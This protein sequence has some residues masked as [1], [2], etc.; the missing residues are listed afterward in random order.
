MSRVSPVTFTGNVT[1]K[2]DAKSRVSVPATWR[3]AHGAVLSLIEAKKKQFPVLKCY[4]QEGFE[5]MLTDIRTDAAARGITPGAINEYIGR[6][7]GNS[8]GAEV[9]TQGKLLIPKA[10][11]ERLRITDSVVLVGRGVYFELWNPEDFAADNSP[12][13]LEL[14]Q[15]YNILS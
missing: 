6:I 7:A 8:F 2:P 13:Q 1:H 3:A 15:Y 9:S 14:D 10:Q 5:E 11:R 4:T 12:E